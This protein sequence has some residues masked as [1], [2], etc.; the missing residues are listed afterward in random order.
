MEVSFLFFFSILG[1]ALSAL[2]AAIMADEASKKNQSAAWWR[3]LWCAVSIHCLLMIVGIAE[4]CGTD[5]NK[6]VNGMVILVVP[7]LPFGV[8]VRFGHAVWFS[9]GIPTS[10]LA[11]ALHCVV[12]GHCQTILH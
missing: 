4:V 7:F 12:S 3:N 5:G 10:F 1:A 9:D 11:Q 2:F 8:L 6:H